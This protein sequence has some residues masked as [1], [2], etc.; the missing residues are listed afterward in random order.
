MS[1]FVSSPGQINKF[2][3]KIKRT[4]PDAEISCKCTIVGNSANKQTVKT[5]F[6]IVFAS[7]IESPKP[8]KKSSQM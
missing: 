5:K 8:A 4:N 3:K 2:V 7:T 1:A 6:T